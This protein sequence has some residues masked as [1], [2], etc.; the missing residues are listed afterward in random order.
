MPPS[1]ALV[2][3][4]ADKAKGVLVETHRLN[5]GE[6]DSAQA[7]RHQDDLQRLADYAG[8]LDLEDVQAA[9]LDLYAYVSVFT[10]GTLKPNAA[11]RTELERLIQDAQAQLLPLAPM[12]AP[13]RDGDAAV[14]LLAPGLEVPPG[15]RMAMQHEGLQLTVFEDG[16]TFEDALRA[17]MP[18]AI[19]IEAAFVGA[20]TELLDDLA[21]KV[22][23]ATRLPLVG[24][25][26]GEPTARIQ[27]LVGG[28]DL[29][30]QRLDD[31][32]AA[33]QI[34]E[35]IGNQ[36]SEPFRV[37]VVDDDRQM[38][39]YCD[40]ILTRAGMRVETTMDAATVPALVK[41]FKPDLVL[42][43]LY[44]PGVDGLTL[45]AELRRQADAVVLPIVFLSGEQSEE[46]R[47][48]AIQVGGDDFLT[49]PIR[50][51]HLVTAVRSRIKRVRAL[52]KQLTQRRGDAQGYMRRG[53]FL[54]HLRE[55]KENA[56]EAGTA[57]VLLVI[58]VDQGAELKERLSLS[59]GHE[60][61]QAV[62]MRLAGAFQPGDRYCLIQEF[63]FGVHINRPGR[64]DLLPFAERLRDV[65]ATQPFKVDGQD[66][67]ITVSLGLALMPGSERNADD[68]INAAFAAA[69]T[70]RRLGGN[71]IEG[72]LSDADSLLPPE[73]LLRIR[74]LLRDAV[75]KRALAIDFQP[76][77]PLRGTETG[78]Y[79]MACYLPDPKEPLGGI[80]RHEFVPVART[81]GL[82]QAIDRIQITHALRALDDQRSQN[83]VRD[84]LVPVDFV[85]MD[86]DQLAW[87]QSEFARRKQVD[88]RLTLEFDAGVLL[89]S[90]G[91]RRVL[92][93]LRA[94]GIR[95][96]AVERSPRLGHLGEL[97]QLPLKVL[98]L[99]AAVLQSM[100][101][102]ISGPVL[103]NWQRSG[104]E[105]VVED[106]RD[107]GAMTRFWN[108][109]V[110][111]LQGDA[112]ATASPRLDFD[113]S[114]ISLS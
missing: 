77:I 91:A 90:E 114:E 12:Q 63:G 96:G 59:V 97:V 80:G 109:G 37:L 24:I 25:D 19:L 44:L 2:R 85:S 14:Y 93:R 82:Q 34:K 73:R 7:E 41:R 49:K 11:Q 68:W 108:L 29:F 103:E 94:D 33:G 28:A 47:F 79:A 17:H 21:A 76:L 52:G 99:P 106:V 31:P 89:E 45:T 100:D 71:R 10:E 51:R 15:L 8:N 36:S 102:E 81:L 9:I 64:D 104:R 66:M 65:V 101:P 40:A 95:L 78:R 88:Q 30:L 87:M 27:A 60:L 112:L 16:D 48:Q 23:E 86:R 26:N 39:T 92:D 46:A 38:C 13:T 84:L 4:F 50:P 62:A 54:D 69:R 98:R 110:D 56:P 35:L 3:A 22:P 70:A 67:Q 6:W 75:D 74:E 53:A 5:A 18:Q 20:T 42:M 1:N 107:L 58:A 61:E 83:R 57:S 43:D 105:L 111:Y 55:H 32:A 72:I 113:F